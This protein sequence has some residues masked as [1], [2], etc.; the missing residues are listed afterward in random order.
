MNKRS[1]ERAWGPPPVPPL[2]PNKRDLGVCLV[3]A[4]FCAPFPKASPSL[5]WF[6]SPARL[7]LSPLLA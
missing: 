7:I 3:A 2:P 1:S 6:C 5:G 4:F